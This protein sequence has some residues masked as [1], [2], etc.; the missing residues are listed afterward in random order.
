MISLLCIIKSSAKKTPSKLVS[1]EDLGKIQQ[2]N[3][4]GKESCTC[5][6]LLAAELVVPFSHAPS[7]TNTCWQTQ[8]TAR[9]AS[10]S[11]SPLP[12]ATGLREATRSSCVGEDVLGHEYATVSLRKRESK[13]HSGGRK[14][15]KYIRKNKR[16][17]HKE[18][19]AR[20]RGRGSVQYIRVLY[21]GKLGM[22]GRWNSRCISQVDSQ[23]PHLPTP[24]Q[25]NRKSNHCIRETLK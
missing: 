19:T 25:R 5:W 23:N 24:P 2:L 1:L 14:P 4:S 20:Q 10:C 15:Q 9:P 3:T 7:R 13:G 17:R 22:S 11:R 8:R 18:Q 16:R 12:G 21:W 6:K